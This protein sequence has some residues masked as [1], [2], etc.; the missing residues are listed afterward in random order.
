L[1][2]S[3]QPVKLQK[4]RVWR[5]YSGGQ[6]LEE[7][8]GKANAADSEFPEEWVASTVAAKNVGREHIV[9]GLSTLDFQ[10][11]KVTLKEVIESDP[12]AFLGSAHVDKFGA[13]TA[14]LVKFLDSS[15]RLTIQVHPDNDFAMSHFSSR[16]GKTESWYVLGGRV[17]DGEEPYLLFG[18]K[19]GVTR[20]QWR[21]LFEKQD[22]DG[23]INALHR[24]PLQE[25]DVYLVEGGVP[26]AIGKGCFLVEVQ[27]PTDLTLRTEKTTPRGNPV[28]DLACH[29]GI[30][31]DQMLDAFHYD[32]LT[33]EETMKRWK[34]Q[35]RM[36]KQAAGGREMRLIG[37]EDTN[38]FRVNLLEVEQDYLLS[39]PDGFC[40][41]IIAAG[42]GAVRWDGNAMPVAASD[43]L[44][45]P[46]DLKEL[47]WVNQ[48][49]PC[50]QLKIV[51]CYPPA[52]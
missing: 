38:C 36:H 40:V 24:V 37:A 17:M 10:G 14:L 51:L 35:P 47:Q 31:F 46:A 8:Q 4:N 1:V 26:H 20:E 43:Q 50:H 42:E 5:T 13:S 52:T 12:A 25:G 15:E 9:E 45:L 41:A 11:M 34:K 21:I 3:K 39:K 27:E 30:G 7:W 18:F 32:A 44:F 2:L 16:F 28:P 33:Y 49:S 22:I 29:Q 19:P 23:M 48:N 6:I